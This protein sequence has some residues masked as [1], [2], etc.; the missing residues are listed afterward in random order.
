MPTTSSSSLSTS[1]GRS[2]PIPR[3]RSQKAALQRQVVPTSRSTDELISNA[4][5]VRDRLQARLDSRAPAAASIS[6]K[7]AKVVE[8]CG[9]VRRPHVSRQDSA[10][11]QKQARPALLSKGR[12][13]MTDAAIEDLLIDSLFPSSQ[14]SPSESSMTTGRSFSFVAP[15]REMQAPAPLQA[16]VVPVTSTA[17]RTSSRLP[18]T[19]QA[20]RAVKFHD[21]G[22]RAAP[23]PILLKSTK[24]LPKGILK[25][26]GKARSGGKRTVRWREDCWA[27]KSRDGQRL[28]EV[29]W[30]KRVPRW[31]GVPQVEEDP[32]GAFQQHASVLEAKA[33]ARDVHPDPTKLLGG[34][35][36]GWTGPDGQDEY[37]FAEESP[38]AH[39]ECQSPGCNKKLLHQGDK[40]VH[41]DR[42]GVSRE[43][44]NSLPHGEN[45]QI[46]NHR[47]GYA[48][49]V[50]PRTGRQYPKDRGM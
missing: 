16:L 41:L 15:S 9:A 28:G 4:R 47:L 50:S 20:P 7:K 32:R 31:I 22:A 19:P 27:V 21:I 33:K 39:V 37:I 8:T 11:L 25:K 17:D 49:S 36:R 44:V 10:S 48:H 30:M 26:N 38:F 40:R 43:L 29:E 13:R 5:H 2:Q 3:I 35:L 42:V 12:Q 14:S 45:L 6:V 46:F 1:S 34:R 23:I 24:A 18:M